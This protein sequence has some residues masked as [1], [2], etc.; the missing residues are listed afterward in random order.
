MIRHVEFV[1]LGQTHLGQ[2]RAL[3]VIVTGAGQVEN[4][5]ITLPSGLPSSAL[6]EAGNFCPLSLQDQRW[7]KQDKN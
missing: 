5:I 6:V 3:V 4:R 1:P 7:Q 2:S